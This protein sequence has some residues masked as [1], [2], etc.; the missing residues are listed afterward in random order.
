MS[1]FDQSIKSGGAESGGVGTSGALTLSTLSFEMDSGAQ[2]DYSQVS[3]ASTRKT[4]TVMQPSPKELS[5]EDCMVAA[6]SIAEQRDEHE[7]V[8]PKVK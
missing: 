7:H 1:S 2:S 3:E 8:Q 4:S 6:P 5:R